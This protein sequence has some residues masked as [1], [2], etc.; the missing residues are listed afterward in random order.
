M[1]VELG[2]FLLMLACV[3][4]FALGIVGLQAGLTQHRVGMALVS[5]LVWL[6]SFSVGLSYLTLTWAFIDND[7][8]LQ[9]VVQQSHSLLPWWYR[10]AA[11]WGG[12]EGS[13]LLL[14]S[15]LVV[16]ILA[17]NWRGRHLSAQVQTLVMAILG[18]IAF[19]ILLFILFTSNPFLRLSEIPL[20]GL[21]LNPLLQDIGLI[22]HPPLLYLGYVGFSVAFAFALA[23][24]LLNRLDAAWARYSRPWTMAAWAFLT[25]GILVGSIWA[26]YE[27]GWGGWW[28]WDPVENA[29]FMPW[30]AGTALIHSLAVTEKRGSFKRWTVLLAILTFSLSLLGMFLVRSGV[31]TSV[32][33]FATD[34]GRGAF[35]L[36]FLVLVVGIALGLY[37]WRSP[38]LNTQ[39]D[40]EPISR[41]TGLLIN[42][43]FLVTACLS[44][45]MGTL[46]PLIMDVLEA[47][48]FSVGPP[49]FN[50]VFVPLMLG[51][52]VFLGLSVFLVWRRQPTNQWLK[53]ARVLALL[54][55]VVGLSLPLLMPQWR[56]GVAVAS[57]LA[58]WVISTALYD[59][60]LRIKRTRQQ[61]GWF[62]TLI[63]QPRSFLG[64][65]MAHI[66]VGV[67]VLGAAW[68]SG[69]GFEQHHKVEPKGTV[70]IAGYDLTFNHLEILQG[71]NYESIRAHVLVTKK[72]KG[73]TWL[74]PEKRK[75]ISSDLPMTE[76]SIY[77]TP[78]EDLYV[79]MGEMLGDDITTSAWLMR[80]YYR[81]LMGW[82]WYGAI[83]MALGAL[84]S[85]TDSRYRTRLKRKKAQVSS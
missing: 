2:H 27:L 14:I 85:L 62:V 47:G 64:M 78:F 66:G 75:Y 34:P 82:V 83:L 50:R 10:V 8:S 6:L 19:G 61:K 5:P 77:H 71:P 32:H 59:V 35:I 76:A 79:S 45:L 22:I 17:V 36:V 41:E 29:S 12:H 57:S 80:F 37:S 49:Y 56:W 74:R 30:L 7:F 16:W 9:Y 21:G 13:L 68:T 54:S 28:F 18:W 70:S 63:K 51:M 53:P 42:N 40:F 73:I 67:F 23:A 72:D 4:A 24:L 1:I 65:H 52:M 55:V 3:L 31:L 58:L 46:F 33:S 69:Y 81:P 84:L 60:T 25:L 15:F 44:V 39:V 11:V 43:I 38:Q 48:K 20:E 26:Y